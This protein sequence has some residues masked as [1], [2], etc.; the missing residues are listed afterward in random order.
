MEL[1]EYEVLFEH[2]DGNKGGLT[3]RAANV[4]EAIK[5]ATKKWP[6]RIAKVTAVVPWEMINNLPLEYSLNF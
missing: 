2:M 5:I 1:V 6:K 4:H 3:V